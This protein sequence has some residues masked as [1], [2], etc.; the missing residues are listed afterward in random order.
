MIVRLLLLHQATNMHAATQY[1]S[2]AYLHSS[3]AFKEYYYYDKSKRLF[4]SDRSPRRGDLVRAC[5][6]PCVTFLK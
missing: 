1:F 2:R 4:G 5:V 6:C 3:H